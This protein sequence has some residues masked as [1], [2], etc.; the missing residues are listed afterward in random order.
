M[1]PH[2]IEPLIEIVEGRSARDVIDQQHTDCLSVVGVRNC[3]VS[4]L[5]RRV[6]YLRADE[7][8]LYLHRLGSEL[9]A[10]GHRGLALKLVFGVS[11]QQLRFADL[12]VANQH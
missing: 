3:P 6:P 1:V 7:G 12:G 4:L 11:E 10:N 2:F 9:H 8:I 5:P